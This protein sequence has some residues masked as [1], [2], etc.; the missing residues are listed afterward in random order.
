MAAAFGLAVVARA[1]LAAGLATAFA[2]GLALALTAGLAL[3]LAFA[4]AAALAAGFAAAADD[5]G[6]ALDFA[7]AFGLEAAADALGD[8]DGDLTMNSPTP[9]F[10]PTRECVKACFSIRHDNG[11]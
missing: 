10:E 4:G 7:A 9:R 6:V 2:A 3:A 1:G 11:V 8:L 5:F